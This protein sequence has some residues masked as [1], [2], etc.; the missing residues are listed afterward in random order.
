MDKRDERLD[1]KGD[2]RGMDIYLNEMQKE[3]LKKCRDFA[4]NEVKPLAREID[5]MER[6]PEENV[7]RIKELGLTGVFVP[8]KYGGAGKD[9]LSY[10]VAV[11]EISKVCATTGVIYSGQQSLFCGPLLKHGTEAQ[12]DYYLRKTSNGEWAA[13][14]GLTEPGAG[15]DIQALQTKAVLEGDEYVLNGSKI[16]ISA[17]DH[18]D[19]N[20]IFAVTGS[21]TDKRGNKIKDCTAFLVERTDPGYSVSKPEHK[22]GIKGSSTCVLNFDDCRIP[23]D[24]VLGKPGEG[25]KIALETLDGGRIGIAAQALGI[26]E[27]VIEE[28]V[29]YLKSKAPRGRITALSQ[30]TQ[31]TLADMYARVQAAKGLVY[32]AAANKDSGQPYSIQAAMAKLYVAET[33]TEVAQKAIELCGHDGISKN[34]VFE[35]LLR[36][37]RITEIYEGT[38]EVQRMV[39]ARWLDAQQI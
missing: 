21:H 9:M 4:E 33:A 8:E 24:R 16:F 30:E 1:E 37:A 17:A 10:V 39:I 14:F 35:R 19:V 27:G 25:F 18:S 13:G 22:M 11:K 28:T 20:I 2:E 12:K 7:K 3:F 23:K 31:F 34:Y 5:E 29:K 38:S 32:N 26:S 6:F 36:D 15:S